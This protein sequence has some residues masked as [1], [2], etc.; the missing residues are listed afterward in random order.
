MIQPYYIIKN[1]DSSISFAVTQF[2]LLDYKISIKPNTVISFNWP[3]KDSEEFMVI[4][5]VEAASNAL[6]T[7]WSRKFRIDVPGQFTIKCPKNNSY[8]YISVNVYHDENSPYYITVSK[9]TKEN[10]PLK[11]VNETKYE[12]SVSQVYLNKKLNQ[13][14]NFQNGEVV[15]VKPMSSAMYGWDENCFPRFLKVRVD[16]AEA[17][18]E[19]DTIKDLKPI[20]L[21]RA[22][23]NKDRAEIKH[24]LRGYLKRRNIYDDRES[25]RTEY[26]ILN[27]SKQMLKI[28]PAEGYEKIIKLQ[29]AQIDEDF[30]R[31]EFVLLYNKESFYFQCRN[32][33]ECKLWVNSLIRSKNLY[34]EDTVSLNL[35]RSSCGPNP[36][37]T[38]GSSPSTRPARTQTR[39]RSS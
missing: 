1:V 38:H 17:E 15:M 29:S 20:T 16:D 33:T 10:L 3:K 12:M 34:Q 8:A 36:Q 30:Q 2:D 19:M 32:I 11:I 18:Y 13:K 28:F 6:Q 5:Q 25:Y 27:S 35:T 9:A 23:T 14:V 39:T 31:N 4:A 21:T 22:S 26:C 37:S 24:Y 7:D